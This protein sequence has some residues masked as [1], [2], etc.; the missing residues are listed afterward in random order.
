MSDDRHRPRPKIPSPTSAPSAPPA[1]PL[2]PVVA[3]AVSRALITRLTLTSFKLNLAHA[4][5]QRNLKDCQSMH[6]TVMRMFRHVNATRDTNEILYR[7]DPSGV[8]WWMHVQ[9]TADADLTMLAP[10]YALPPVRQRDDLWQKCEALQVGQQYPF[11][12]VANIV[13][14]DF[15]AKRT[16]TVYDSAAQRDWLYRKGVQHGFMLV[17]DAQALVKLE[18]AADPQVNGVHPNG[19]LSYDAFRIS[20]TLQ[21]TDPAALADAIATGIGKAKAYGFGL[22]S[23]VGL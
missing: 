14:R 6:R 7:V 13:K 2:P 15:H 18:I 5:V 11:V 10:G 9:S 12:L 23:L 16:R 17:A 21:V 3:P 1:P 19:A 8:D 20:G 4:E 22:L